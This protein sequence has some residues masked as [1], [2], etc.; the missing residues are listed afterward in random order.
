MTNMASMTGYVHNM[1]DKNQNF[2]EFAL[3]CSRAFGALIQMRDDPINA[4]IPEE[5][6]Y[7]LY[8]EEKIKSYSKE[9]D[10]FL[11]MNKIE[12]IRYGKIK[13]KTKLKFTKKS[14]KSIRQLTKKLM[15]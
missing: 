12:M 11:K 9:L 7:D 8:H 15:P 14:L 10:D 4:D 2:N 5:I 6:K 3:S 1:I 13:L